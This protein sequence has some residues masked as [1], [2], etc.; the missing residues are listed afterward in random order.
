LKQ[1]FVCCGGSWEVL[2]PGD[3]INKEPF[4]E[5]FSDDY[6]FDHDYV[7]ITHAGSEWNVSPHFVQL[8]KSVIE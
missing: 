8:R 3:L 5:W 7:K 2:I 6:L 4:E 1:I